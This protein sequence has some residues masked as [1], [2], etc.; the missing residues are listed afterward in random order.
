MLTGSQELVPRAFFIPHNAFHCGTPIH[1]KLYHLRN[2]SV[3]HAEVELRRFWAKHAQKL[4]INKISTNY[5]TYYN[6]CQV[7]FH[8]G[9]VLKCTI[10]FLTV[11]IREKYVCGL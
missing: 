4:S 5:S 3:S 9:N 10:F 6:L 7:Y 2:Q 11:P 1:T 8:Y